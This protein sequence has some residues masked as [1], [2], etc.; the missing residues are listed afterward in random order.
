MACNLNELMEKEN[1]ANKNNPYEAGK[2]IMVKYKHYAYE[3]HLSNVIGNGFLNR[4]LYKRKVIKACFK[5]LNKSLASEG[6]ILG[7]NRIEYDVQKIND[8]GVNLVKL[9]IDYNTIPIW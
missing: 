1:E 8:N 5:Q 3:S 6:Y 4:W 2:S 9:R 7:S